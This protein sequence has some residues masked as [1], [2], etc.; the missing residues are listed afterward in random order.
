M[1][2]KKIILIII[3]ISFFSAGKVWSQNPYTDPGQSS[4][5]KNVV[6]GSIHIIGL[7]GGFDGSYERMIKESQDKF[8]TSLW[9]RASY[10]TWAVGFGGEGTHVAVGLAA[11]TG[12]WKSH[13]EFN[14]GIASFYDSLDYGFSVSDAVYFN[15]PKPS[16]SEY[17]QLL[18]TVAAGYRF[19]K[20]GGH[21]I[22]RTG[23][24]FPEGVYASLGFCF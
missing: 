1:N 21:F 9:A 4:L 5:N 24:G 14:A 12:L 16:K 13:L 3:A 7:G 19:Q 18:P 22:F 23:I 6:F 10:G 20:P 15:E 17:R 8:I 2:F 11:L